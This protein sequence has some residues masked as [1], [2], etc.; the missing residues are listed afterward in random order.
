[1]GLHL[2]SGAKLGSDVVTKFTKVPLNIGVDVFG[3]TETLIP[4]NSKMPVEVKRIF[5]TA[6]DNQSDVDIKYEEKMKQ[7]K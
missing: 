6:N 2:Y 4:L 3:H 5:T 1:M 7:E